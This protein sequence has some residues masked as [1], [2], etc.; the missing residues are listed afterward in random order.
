[1]TLRDKLLPVLDKAGRAKM[2]AF[3]LRPNGLTIRT[4]T[5][6]VDGVTWAPGGI[7]A[8]GAIFVDSDL[9]LSPTPRIREVSSR[10]VAS[11]GGLYQDGDLR[12]TKITPQYTGAGGGGYTPLQLRPVGAENVEILY[13]VTGPSAGEHELVDS[14]FS[15]NWGYELTIRRLRT[16]P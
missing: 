14:D 1:M 15:R 8:P 11:S 13:V 16:T 5:W 2:Q 12:V 4:R 9:V 6:F 7:R 10:E 3:G